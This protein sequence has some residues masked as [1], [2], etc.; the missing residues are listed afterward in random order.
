MEMQKQCQA[1][2][3]EKHNCENSEQNINKMSKLLIP[4]AQPWQDNLPGN[5]NGRQYLYRFGVGG[6]VKRGIVR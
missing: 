1:R 5:T 3:A 2:R 6:S 4:G